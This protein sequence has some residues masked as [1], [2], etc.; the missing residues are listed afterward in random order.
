MASF[1]SG[2]ISSATLDDRSIARPKRTHL[3]F[4]QLC[5]RQS[6]AV[7]GIPCNAEGPQRECCPT[8]LVARPSAN[9]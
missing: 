1:G 9:V 3:D 7:P 4:G 6:L 8:E 2:D 5:L